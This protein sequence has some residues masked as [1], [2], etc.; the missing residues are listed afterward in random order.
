MLTVRRLHFHVLV[1][2]SSGAQ[3]EQ[4][5]FAVE[6]DYIASPYSA[7]DVV[8]ECLVHERVYLP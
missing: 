3:A 5:P 6:V 2:V 8:T 7:Y 4:H 1:V